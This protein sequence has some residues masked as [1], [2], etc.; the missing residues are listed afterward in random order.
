LKIGVLQ[1]VWVS[2]RQILTYKETSPAN[3]F[4]TGI[5]PVN[6]IQLCRLK[7]SHKE[8]L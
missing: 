5:W 8:T 2:I 4:R 7:F 1:G 6:A 3:H